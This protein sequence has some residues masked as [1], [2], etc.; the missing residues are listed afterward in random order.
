MIAKLIEVV[1][2]ATKLLVVLVFCYCCVN[3]II[4]IKSQCVIDTQ[5][6]MRNVQFSV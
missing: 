1:D 6:Q 4:Y 3:V 2:L 5:L